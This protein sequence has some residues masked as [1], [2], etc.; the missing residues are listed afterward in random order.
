VDA[1]AHSTL[2]V[3]V[4]PSCT[5]CR[6]LLPALRSLAKRERSLRMVLASDGPRAEHEAFVMEHALGDLAY[7][8]SQP[9]GLAYRVARLPWA[10]LVD[11]QGVL[12][13]QGLVNS[14]EQLE[15][16]LEAEAL[17]VATLQEHL[18]ERVQGEGA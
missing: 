9:L 16:L 4:S 17:G 1:S 7:V 14:R 2:L 12:R 8:I 13:S 11:A 10:V 6:S 18:A 15:S 5:V 3:F